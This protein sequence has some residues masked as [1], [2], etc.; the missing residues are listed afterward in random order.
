MENKISVIVF[1]LGNVL[2]PFDYENFLSELEAR[3]KG[4]GEEFARKYRENYE[5]HRNFEKGK[6]SKQEFI[7][8]MMD[9]TNYQMTEE[10]FCFYFS[11][12]FSVN[13]NV[14][15]MLPV[16][17]R[18]Y[19]L[20]LLS[21][22]NEIHMEYGWKK[23]EFLKYFDKLILSHEVG[24]AKPEAEIYKAVEQFTRKEP[25]EH[26]FIDDVAEYTEA[27]KKLGWDAIQFKN[28]EDLTGEFLKR[29][30]LLDGSNLKNN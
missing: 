15:K 27:A 26:I 12:I 7:D 23:Y 22:T 8:I 19:T 24:A 13:E 25:I 3:E 5:I 4:L 29:G 10:E 20:I 9:W 28:S 17:K 16:L 6:M 21:N 11:N 30:I 2:I 1:D 18:N 14:V